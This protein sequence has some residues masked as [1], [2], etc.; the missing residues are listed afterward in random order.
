MLSITHILILKLN[1][2]SRLQAGHAHLTHSNIHNVLT[3]SPINTN[4]FLH[5]LLGLL[6]FNLLVHLRI[7]VLSIHLQRMWTTIPLIFMKS[8]GRIWFQI[9]INSLQQIKQ[10]SLVSMLQDLL[11]CSKVAVCVI[12]VSCK[13]TV[14]LKIIFL[15]LKSANPVRVAILFKPVAVSV[16]SNKIK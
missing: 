3:S 7:Q 11:Y 16:V 4:K 1:L 10:D 5:L 6:T 12:V 15:H 9:I 2:S 13:A 14:Y 8:L